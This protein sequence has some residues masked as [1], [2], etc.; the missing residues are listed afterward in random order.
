MTTDPTT[1]PATGSTADGSGGQATDERV[2]VRAARTPVGTGAVQVVGIVL[3]VLLTAL[4]VAAVRDAL[5]ATGVID[6][7]P[8]LLGAVGRLDG[9]RPAGWALAVAVLL[10]LV[11]GWLVLAGLRP[12]PR[13]GLALRA[14]TGVFL[15]PAGVSRLASAAAED[16]DGVLDSSTSTG[17]RSVSVTITTTGDASTQAAVRTAVTRRLSHL[18]PTPTVRVRTRTRQDR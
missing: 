12:R 14:G 8:W 3:A 10:V 6:G 7:S 16:V 15:R 13:T 1:G 11:G 5:L 17:R 2:P 9:L 18:D 4:G